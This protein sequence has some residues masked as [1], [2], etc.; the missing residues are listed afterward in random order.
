MKTI[1]RLALF[2][3]MFGIVINISAQNFY[4][5]VHPETDS[6]VNKITTKKSNEEDSKS[7]KYTWEFDSSTPSIFDN[8]TMQKAE[9]HEFG[10][11][12]ACLKVLM[13]E[14]YVTQE[15][16]VPGDP[17]KRT[18]IKK[19]SIYNT[20]RKIEKHFR[21]E[22]KKGNITLE[23]AINDFTH[24]L[25]VS[26]AIIGETNTETFETALDQNKKN[27]NDQINIFNQVK[28]NSIY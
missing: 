23:D 10:A 5:N 26:L 2:I 13:E 21:K 24:I 27:I 3:L 4:A 20:T 14:Y 16:L 25:E 9:E 7:I 22:V 15:E 6:K 17:A 18:I 8:N 12:V 11:K 28:I 1:N 19:P